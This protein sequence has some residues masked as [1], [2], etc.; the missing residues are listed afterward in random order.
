MNRKSVEVLTYD[1]RDVFDETEY[2]LSFEGWTVLHFGTFL[3]IVGSR[4]VFQ[5][6]SHD[7]HLHVEKEM[8]VQKVSA[9][10]SLKQKKERKFDILAAKI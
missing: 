1:E 9:K 2:R 10:Q 8:V 6:G 5:D 3:R 4:I 7:V